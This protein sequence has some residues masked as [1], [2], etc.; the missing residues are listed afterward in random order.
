[1]CFIPMPDML[2]II[3]AGVAVTVLS[4]TC[5]FITDVSGHILKRYVLCG[6]DG[7]HQPKFLT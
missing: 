2:K 4:V 1:M 3:G 5:T 6:Q 7:E